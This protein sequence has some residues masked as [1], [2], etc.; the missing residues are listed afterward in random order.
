[1]SRHGASLPT[2]VGNVPNH[3][4]TESLRAAERRLQT[5]ITRSP[6]AGFTALVE[7]G[8]CGDALSSRHAGVDDTGSVV[9]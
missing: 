3:D 7:S 5:G 6:R 1:M 8:A 2:I 9:G 4:H